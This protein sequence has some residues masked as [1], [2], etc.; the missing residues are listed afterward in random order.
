M[1]PTQPKYID[2]IAMW[3]GIKKSGACSLGF[4]DGHSGKVFLDAITTTIKTGD[5]R[6]T[7][8]AHVAPN[9]NV[10]KMRTLC[11]TVLY[12]ADIYSSRK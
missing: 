2:A 1:N 4:A 9:E 5:G 11:P 8:V 7:N 10:N 12:M 6:G 3:H